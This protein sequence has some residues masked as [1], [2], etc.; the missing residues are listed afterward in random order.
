MNRLNNE[1]GF[2]LLNVI[3]L[4]LITSVAAMILMNAAPRVRNPQSMLRLTAIYLANEYFAHLE[5]KAAAGIEILD[6][7][8]FPTEN[9]D[10]L[11]TEN[12]GAGKLIQF[13]ITPKITPKGNLREVTVK[14]EWTID[15]RKDYVEME[16]TIRFVPK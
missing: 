5:S 7:H 14:F 13:E 1:R 3:F 11:T 2:I 4:T 10:D 16:R 12:F 8:E 6:N 15:G 9:K